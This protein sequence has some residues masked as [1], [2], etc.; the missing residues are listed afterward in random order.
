MLIKF[1]YYVSY[2][3]STSTISDPYKSW[4]L[5]SSEREEKRTCGQEEGA[6]QGRRMAA[7]GSNVGTSICGA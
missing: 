7:V 5:H 3:K 1:A 2:H 6:S 4:S